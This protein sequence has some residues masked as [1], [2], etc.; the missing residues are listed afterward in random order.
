MERRAQHPCPPKVA[1]TVSMP[2]LRT[3]I[4]RISFADGSYLFQP[5]HIPGVPTRQVFA[6]HVYI[7][8]ESAGVFIP[9]LS[10]FLYDRINHVPPP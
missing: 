6:N 2:V 5:L 7:V 10:D 4:R 3:S 8:V 1:P 9:I